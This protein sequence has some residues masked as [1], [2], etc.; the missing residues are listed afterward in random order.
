MPS[1]PLHSVLLR[2]DITLNLELAVFSA[3][4]AGHQVPAVPCPTALV[5]QAHHAYTWLLYVQAVC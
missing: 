5:L 3:R 4:L 2:Q 1:V